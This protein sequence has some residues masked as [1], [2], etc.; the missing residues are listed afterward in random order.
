MYPGVTVREMLLAKRNEG[1][2]EAERWA[3]CFIGECRKSCRH[4]AQEHAEARV[5]VACVLKDLLTEV[6]AARAAGF[7]EN[8]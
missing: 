8:P 7:I 4:T 6:R 1:E 5:F 3:D 2:A